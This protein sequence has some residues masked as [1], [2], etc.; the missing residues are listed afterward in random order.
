MRIFVCSV[1]I[2]F[3][4]GHG[5]V[6]VATA[7][8]PVQTVFPIPERAGFFRAMFV[9]VLIFHMTFKCDCGEEEVYMG[10]IAPFRVQRPTCNKCGK[11]AR[12]YAYHTHY[13][14]IDRALFGPDR[15]KSKRH[16][17]ET[18][19]GGLAFTEYEHSMVGELTEG[20]LSGAGLTFTEYE[21]SMRIRGEAIE[22][23]EESVVS[24]MEFDFI[25][26]DKVPLCDLDCSRCPSSGSSNGA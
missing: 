8:F 24:Q 21:N 4:C 9:R 7:Q 3:K 26:A 18:S 10:V 6:V 15:F 13:G 25:H 11:L 23:T 19:G 20:N 1:W 17:G 12:H 22:P 5:V 2:P 14:I 16:T